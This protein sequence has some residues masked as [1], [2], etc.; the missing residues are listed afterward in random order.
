MHVEDISFSEN[1][2]LEV[3]MEQNEETEERNR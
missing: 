1:F 3:M 2:V